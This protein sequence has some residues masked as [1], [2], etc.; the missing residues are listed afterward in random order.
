MK[1]QARK[2]SREIRQKATVIRDKLR[3]AVKVVLGEDKGTSSTRRQ[4]ESHISVTALVT[5][6]TVVYITR[7]VTLFPL[8]LPTSIPFV[9]VH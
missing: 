1:W 6:V 5:T 3:E 7:S 8:F 4:R 2:R 9:C